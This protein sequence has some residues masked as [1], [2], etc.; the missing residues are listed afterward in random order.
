MRDFYDGEMKVK[1]KGE[2]YLPKLSG[3]TTKRYEAFKERAITYGPQAVSR[4]VGSLTGAVFRRAPSFTLPERIKYLAND[5][6]GTGLSLS[7]L[8][9]W[10][11]KEIMI[12]GRAAIVADRDPDG[13]RPY[14][15]C[16][17]AEDLINWSEGDFVVIAEHK[18]VSDPD[19]KYELV[20]D[21]SYRE[22]TLDD[23]GDYIVNVWREDDKGEPYIESTFKPLRNGR[24]FRQIPLTVVSP[25]GTDYAIEKP[26]IQDLVDLAV[27]SVQLGAIYANALLVTSCP[28]PVVIGDIDTS[29]GKFEVHLGSDTALVLPSGSDAKF[30]EYQGNGID[31]ISKAIQEVKEFMAILGARLLSTGPVA[32]YS[33]AA[34]VKSRESLA[35]AVIAAIVSSVESALTKQLRFVAEWENADPEEVEVELNRDLIQVALDANTINS[36][37]ASL[38]AGAI[39][40]ETFFYNLQTGGFAEPGVSYSEELSR[41][42]SGEFGVPEKVG[43]AQGANDVGIGNS[44]EE[45]ENT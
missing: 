1:S 4:T 25:L 7:E 5:A 45:S 30:L 32:S 18:L 19:D 29:D 22:L 36:L 10:L 23:S 35:G 37:M 28:T 14:L 26:P 2:K 42:K 44:D 38:Q 13:G 9:M 21:T 27:K 6:T 12:T 3:Q 33:T 41:I 17:T 8:A 15:V 24:A 34:E 31:S 39:S 40:Q 16:V 43:V 20:E 11:V